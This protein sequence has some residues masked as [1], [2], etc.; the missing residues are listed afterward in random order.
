MAHMM[1]EHEVLS[2]WTI[3]VHLVPDFGNSSGNVSLHNVRT[4]IGSTCVWYAVPSQLEGA[5]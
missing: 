3:R 1:F 4:V 2:G 5:G